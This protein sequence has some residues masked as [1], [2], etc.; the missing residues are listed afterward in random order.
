MHKQ[1]TVTLSSH[2]TYELIKTYEADLKEGLRIPAL[3]RDLLTDYI[4]DNEAPPLEPT[5]LEDRTEG[6][7]TFHTLLSYD[8]YFYL[9]STYPRAKLSALLRTAIHY[10]TPEMP[11]TDLEERHDTIAQYLPKKSPLRFP[12][13]PRTARVRRY[14]EVAQNPEAAKKTAISLWQS[15]TFILPKE[16]EEDY[17]SQFNITREEAGER[18]HE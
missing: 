11:R 9:T 16:D 2:Q 10:Y 7:Y 17:L 3:I 12:L 8:L 15:S 14:S 5:P 6:T 13:K 4:S 18:G 1:I